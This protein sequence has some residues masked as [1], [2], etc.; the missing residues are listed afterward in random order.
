[1]LEERLKR[2]IPLRWDDWRPG[3]QRVYVSDIRR[4]ET[5]LGWKPEIDAE[6]GVAQL[7]NWV[8]QNRAAF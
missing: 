5:V 6:T 1:M 3:D 7:I 8:A 2:R 4:L